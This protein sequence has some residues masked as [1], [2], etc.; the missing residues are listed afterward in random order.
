MDNG[1]TN[2]KKNAD[3]VV[4]GMRRKS[5]DFKELVTSVTN[6]DTSKSTVIRMFTAMLLLPKSSDESTPVDESCC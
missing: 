6:V 2:D 4:D 5:A 3:A 1:S